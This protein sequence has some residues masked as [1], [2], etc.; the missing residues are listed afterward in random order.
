[1]IW[2]KPTDIFMSL[3]PQ[4]GNILRNRHYNN[5]I[6]LTAQYFSKMLEYNGLIYI[7]FK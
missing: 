5:N 2:D 3:D 4:N 6:D 7:F 1:M